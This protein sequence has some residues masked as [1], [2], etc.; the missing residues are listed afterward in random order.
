MQPTEA[1]YALNGYRLKT[2]HRLDWQAQYEQAVE[3]FVRHSYIVL[4]NDQQT[5]DLDALIELHPGTAVT[6]LKLI[7]LV[8]G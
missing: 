4:V 3:A 2:I 5:A 1:E 7:P 8:G 6:F